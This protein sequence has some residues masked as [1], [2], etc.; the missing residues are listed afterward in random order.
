V[1]PLREVTAKECACL[2][3]FRRYRV[4][5]DA[6]APK[7][8]RPSINS[9]ASAFVDGLLASVPSSVYTIT[10][11]AGSLRA[12]D[13]ND[14]EAAGGRPRQKQ[15]SRAAAAAGEYAEALASSSAGLCRLCSAPLTAAEAEGGGGGS[16]DGGG[17]QRRR[18]AQGGGGAAAL[19]RVCY[20]CKGQVV[21]RFS[22]GAAALAAL[23]PACMASGVSGP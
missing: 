11:A 9:L 3:W 5:G 14:V 23:L 7:A 4:A 8:G 21:D 18:E 17:E 6:A 19:G 16:S 1:Y 22:G 20:S 10:R 13:F 12:F 15:G 2:C